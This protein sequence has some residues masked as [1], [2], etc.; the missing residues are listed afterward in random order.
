MAGFV[1]GVRSLPVF[2][3]FGQRTLQAE[4]RGRPPPH[5]PFVVRGAYQ[6]VRHPLYLF[7]LV[8]IWSVPA[9]TLDRLLFDVLWTVWTVAAT[10]WEERD[11]V[12]GFGDDYRRY[13]RTVPMLLPWRGPAGRAL[14]GGPAAAGPA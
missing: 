13:Q 6:W 9:A 8:L 12:A 10:R 4:L 7:M 3:P 2:D 11:L 1:W 5:S 14:A